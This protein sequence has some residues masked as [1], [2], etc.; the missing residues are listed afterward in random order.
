MKGNNAQSLYALLAAL[1]WGLAIPAQSVCADFLG[2]FSITAI[3]SIIAGP[4]ML[5]FCLLR[6]KKDCGTWRDIIIGSFASGFALFVAINAQQ[7]ALNHGTSSGKAAFISTFYIVAVPVCQI[8]FGKKVSKRHWLAVAIAIGGL[9]FLCITDTFTISVNDLALLL[10]ALASTI[11]IFSIERFSAKVDPFVLTCGQL[12]VIAGLSFLV[13]LPTENITASAVSSCILQL[14]YISVCA[15]C[16]GYTFQT[17]AQAS[18]NTTIVSLLL[19]LESFFAAVGGALLLG[20]RMSQGE[21]IGCALML[22]ATVIAT[23]PGKAR[24]REPE[25]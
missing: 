3:R 22:T 2:P 6:R 16:L 8:F 1:A 15:S 13:A 12:F 18:G 5:A 25:K 19:S 11:Q 14:L 17:L 7:F 10:C 21:L 23:L 24:S 9:Y 20:E 4:I